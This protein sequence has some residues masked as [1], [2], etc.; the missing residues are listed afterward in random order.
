M[1]LDKVGPNEV[2]ASDR[3]VACTRRT[4]IEIARQLARSSSR[5]ATIGEVAGR[6]FF[7]PRNTIPAVIHQVWSTW[8]ER[9]D[10]VRG[11]SIDG[12]TCAARIIKSSRFDRRLKEQFCRGR[13]SPTRPNW[14]P[15]AIDALTKER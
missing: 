1:R 4:E 2:I 14:R 6:G 15:G 8:P 5:P 13:P 12:A 3:L 7:K 9:P 11:Q 10:C